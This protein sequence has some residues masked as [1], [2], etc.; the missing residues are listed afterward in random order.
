MASVIWKQHIPPE[1]YFVPETKHVITKPLELP[2]DAEVL[3][4]GTDL[5]GALCFWYKTSGNEPTQL[6]RVCAVWTGGIAP[7]GQYLGTWTGEML[8]FDS[9]QPLIYHIFLIDG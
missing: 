3:S 7:H 6:K 9:G 5:H 2:T 8:L 4:L 1:D